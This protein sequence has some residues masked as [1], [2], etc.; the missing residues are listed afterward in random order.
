MGRLRVHGELAGD[1]R[2][3]TREVDN[4]GPHGV[5]SIRE[6]RSE[7]S[8][9]GRLGRD[10]EFECAIDVVDLNPR[11]ALVDARGRSG[12]LEFKAEAPSAHGL[13]PK[14]AARLIAP[15]PMP[16]RSRNW[17]RV[18]RMSSSD[19]LCSRMYFSVG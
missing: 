9:D 15:K 8:D 14:T 2:C 3:V 16:D 1:R 19:G 13:M 17:R 4:V 6:G 7:S 10:R 18:K 5:R 12:I 11:R